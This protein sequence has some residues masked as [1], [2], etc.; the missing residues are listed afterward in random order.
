MTLLPKVK[1]KSQVSFPAQ[2]KN[3][4]GIAIAKSNGVY[5]IG[6]DYTQFGVVSTLPTSPHSYSLFYDTVLQSYSLVPAS[7]LGG[8]GG[9]GG[10]ADAPVDG[11]TYARN[12]AAWVKAISRS[13]T[14]DYDTVAQATAA[15]ISTL[16]MYVRVAGFYAAGDGGSATYKR[17]GFLGGVFG[18]QSA[19]GAWWALAE[20]LI[21]VRMTGA[22]GDGA[23]DDTAAIGNAIATLPA[24][25]G[26]VY[27]PPGKFMITSINVIAGVALQGAGQYATE[28]C[29]TSASA[30]AI[31]CSGAGSVVRDCH[32]TSS[33]AAASRTG[34][35]IKVTGSVFAGA[36]RC[37][38]DGHNYGIY[39]SGPATE[40]SYCLVGGAKSHGIVFD[41][42]VTNMNETS[43]MNCQ[44]NANGGDGF[45]SI[46]QTGSGTASQSAGLFF[47]RPTASANGGDGMAFVNECYDVHIVSPEMSGN[48]NIN[49]NTASNGPGSNF[50]IVGG[51]IERSTSFAI[52]I[53]QNVD[54]FTIAGAIIS[55]FAATAII[56]DGLNATITGNVFG[57]PFAGG[58]AIELGGHSKGAVII[59]N[60]L[61]T[62]G[63]TTPARGIVID[64]GAGSF[65][66]VGND[67]SNNTAGAIFGT[68]PAGSA[69][70]ANKGSPVSTLGQWTGS[71]DAPV[72]GYI[73]VIDSTG[74]NRK[75]ATIA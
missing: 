40:L 25:G 51:L 24:T 11:F 62:S 38:V 10:L 59:G 12:S 7:L 53:G 14:A 39:T 22:K 18:F 72:N 65:T 42:S 64:A 4:T 75:I 54:G 58:G 31:V 19:D 56:N 26:L 17:V 60:A 36:H 34:V 5:T 15:S 3:G 20:P 2:V 48:G 9:G 73:N 35:G 71:A 63:G 27:V 70:I 57:G 23:T 66:A 68:I 6:L 50:T 16:L 44:S 47:Y 33:V 45:H 29:T 30:D 37:R 49:I 41:G 61:S 55:T 8:G 21:N 1:L 28:I 32:V 69:V 46:G 43:V 13:E 67:L 52:W 74:T